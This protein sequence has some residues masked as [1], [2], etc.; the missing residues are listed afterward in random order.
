ML[1]GRQ[2]FAHF[3]GHRDVVT[4]L[5]LSFTND[6]FE[7]E[8]TALANAPDLDNGDSPSQ[9]RLVTDRRE[10][11]TFSGLANPLGSLRSLRLW[12]HASVSQKQHSRIF[13][14]ESRFRAH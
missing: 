3:T 9:N 10:S 7:I 4:S 11:S 12:S 2:L 6:H 14:S 13:G 8:R 5:A 1:A